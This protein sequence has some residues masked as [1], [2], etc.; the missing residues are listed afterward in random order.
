MKEF[1]LIFRNRHLD[2]K[3]LSP[4][5]MQDIL[6]SWM[7]WMANIAAQ[8]KLAD[9]GHRLGHAN[10]KVVKVNGIVTDGPYT[11]I[12]EFIN[13]YV[14]IRATT[15]DEAVEIAKE[16]PVLLSGGNVEIRAAVTPD[17]NS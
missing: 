9:K 2:E 13:G 11:E 4:Q 1:V 3:Q 5:Q 12:K 10:A 16:C 17:D 7:N 8:N 15:V 14:V 6:N